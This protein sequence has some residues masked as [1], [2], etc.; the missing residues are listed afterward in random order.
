MTVEHAEPGSALDDRLRQEQAR[1]IF[2][3]LA[4]ARDRERGEDDGR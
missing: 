1:A 2:D 3:L 4:S